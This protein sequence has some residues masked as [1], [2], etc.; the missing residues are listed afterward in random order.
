M[1][2]DWLMSWRNK[3]K[4]NEEYNAWYRD[5]REKNRDKVRAISRKH[6]QLWR[7]RAGRNA[8]NPEKQAARLLLNLA[9]RRKEILRSNCEVC[10]QAQ[11]QAHHDVYNKPLD[12]RWLC[13]LHHA[14][15]HKKISTLL[16]CKKQ[17]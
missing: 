7:K 16:K 8:H 15:L 17:L 9:I 13:H 14:Q 3:F 12:V 6:A 10:G 5:Y 2:Y 4:S 11:A 1:C